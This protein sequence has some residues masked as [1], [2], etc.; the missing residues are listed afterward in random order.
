[1]NLDTDFTRFSGGHRDSVA[2]RGIG[3]NYEFGIIGDEKPF[4]PSHLLN[5]QNVLLFGYHYFA[6]QLGIGSV[7]VWIKRFDN[8]FGSFLSDAELAWLNKGHGVYCYRDLSINAIA[9]QRQHPTQKPVSLMRWCIHKIKDPG[10]I[11]D[12][13]AGSGSTLVAAKELSLKAIGIEL[14]EKYCEIT[15]KRVSGVTVMCPAFTLPSN[16]AHA[17]DAE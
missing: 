16:K 14:V 17:V 5:Y 9:R 6:K 3:R 7:L 15:A 12:P 8:A 4:N 10:L 1:M 13:Y 11:C 2:K